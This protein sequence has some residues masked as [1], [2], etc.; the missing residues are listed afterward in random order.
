MKGIYRYWRDG[1]PQEVLEPWQLR[2]DAE[3]LVLRGQRQIAGHLA[4][5][6]EARYLNHTCTGLRLAWYSETSSRVVHYRMQEGALQWRFDA[7]PAMQTL[8]LPAG[9][10]L[11]P[12]LRAASGPLLGALVAAPRT[13]V[14]PNIR[15]PAQEDYLRPLL[16]ERRA[17]LQSPQH[18]RYYGGEYGDAGAD[19]WLDE[20]G[21]V[22]RYHWQSPR[23]EWEARL[24]D[25]CAG[26][27]WG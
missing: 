26:E 12:L 3:G 16:S 20:N 2:R 27:V 25:F 17:V 15:N 10:L 9:T 5:E 6:V 1:L 8:A 7:E 13:L 14:L 11:F 18:Y 23:G 4:L 22:S 21:M 24:E 19:Y